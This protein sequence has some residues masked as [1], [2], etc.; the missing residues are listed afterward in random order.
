M[1]YKKIYKSNGWGKRSRVRSQLEG[2]E[3][4]EPGM[5]T[6]GWKKKQHLKQGLEM[7]ISTRKQGSER[8]G[9]QKAGEHRW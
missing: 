9:L 2:F 1:R 8:L 7:L 5:Q 4:R 6:T 3:I